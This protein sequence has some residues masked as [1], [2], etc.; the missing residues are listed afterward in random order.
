MRLSKLADIANSVHYRLMGLRLG[1]LQGFRSIGTSYLYYRWLI[2][3]FNMVGFT[4]LEQ[5]LL[6]EIHRDLFWES[7]RPYYQLY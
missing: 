3:D 7:L 1:I 4:A 5:K 6:V 2:T